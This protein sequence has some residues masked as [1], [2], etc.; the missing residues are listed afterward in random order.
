MPRKRTLL[1]TTVAAMAVAATAWIALPA[2]AAAPT[3]SLRT[4]SDWGSGWQ[5]EVTV[6]NTGAA[7]MTSW[8][9]EFDLPA[10]ASIGSF[11]NAQAT[12]AGQHV[13][14]AN[15]SWNGAVA[16]G[17][18]TT[19]GVVGAGGQPVNC[20]INGLPCNGVVATATPTT[21]A[22]TTSS[23]APTS[24][25]PTP[26]TATPTSAPATTKADVPPASDVLPVTVENK[27]GRSETVFLYVLGVNLATGKLGYVNAAGA[28]TAWTGGGTVPVPAPDV[29]IPLTGASTTIKIPRGLSGRLYMSF[30]QKLDFRLTTASGSPP[31]G[32]SSRR[33]GPAA[34]PTTTSC[35]TGASSPST[36]AACS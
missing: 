20:K 3:A 9:V 6:N 26:T 15:Q 31:T 21:V 4:V 23:P 29:S 18:T 11:W 12:L 10:G 35:S 14:F 28:F 8:T 24:P 36:P 2:S 30:G 34:T 16:V 7:A 33:R 22:P 5:D 25:A 17:A 32:S 13:T 19:F 1:L 27:T